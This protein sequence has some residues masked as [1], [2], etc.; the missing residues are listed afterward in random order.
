MKISHEQLVLT[1]ISTA[2]T[3]GVPS[4]DE[5]V[6]ELL[7]DFPIVTSWNKIGTERPD[8]AS[9]EGRDYCSDNSFMD[10]SEGMTVEAM[11]E[12]VNLWQ[13]L[14]N[15]QGKPTLVELKAELTEKF[16]YPAKKKAWSLQIEERPSVEE[17]RF[18]D[19]WA[20]NVILTDETTLPEPRVSSSSGSSS[21]E[22]PPIR[23]VRTAVVEVL[24]SETATQNAGK[25]LLFDVADVFELRGKVAEQTN[26]KESEMQV[27]RVRVS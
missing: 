13:D 10:D 6:L 15:G 18:L 19:V 8:L 22:N 7:L 2:S 23:L 20:G 3:H 17:L 9:P 5:R 16:K 14:A 27:S 12:I 1:S 11:T 21:L 4:L 24:V 25:T 26:M